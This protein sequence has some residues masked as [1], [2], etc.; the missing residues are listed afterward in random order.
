MSRTIVITAPTVQLALASAS[1]PSKQSWRVVA[2]WAASP[3]T[4]LLLVMTASLPI[5]W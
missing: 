4:Y 2:V 3:M 1:G 5:P